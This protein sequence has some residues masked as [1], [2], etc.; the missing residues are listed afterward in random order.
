VKNENPETET[1]AEA[2]T[3]ASKGQGGDAKGVR[4]KRWGRRATVARLHALG[5]ARRTGASERD[6]EKASGTPR[7]T[8]RY[9]ERRLRTPD[10]PGEV[11][12]FF[13]SPAGLE[14]LHRIVV[15]AEFVMTLRSPDGIRPV[16]EFLHLS[17]LAEFVGSSFGSVQKAT[18]QMQDEV[19]AYGTGQRGAL[20]G[21]MQPKEITVCEDE[22]FHPEICLVAIEP[23]S[24]F[25]LLEQYAERRDAETWNEAMKE[26]MTDLPVKVMQSTA[27]EAKALLA[28]AQEAFEAPHSPDVFHVQYE[29]SRSISAPLARRVRQAEAGVEAAVVA[30]EKLNI[31]Q[32]TYEEERQGPGRRR[33]YESRVNSAEEAIK[34]AERKVE[35]AKESQKAA[36]EAVA[37]ISADY[38][39]VRL[40]DGAAQDSNAVSKALESRFAAIEEIATKADLPDRCPAGIAKARR[41]LPAMIAAIQFTHKTIATQVAALQLPDAL[42]REVIDRL[43]P[44]LYLERAASRAPTAEKRRA[45]ESQAEAL[46]SPLRDRG[47]PLQLVSKEERAKIETVARGSA[48]VFQRSSSCVEGRNGQLSLF[49]HG[50]HRLR[51]EKLAALTVIHNYFVRRADGTTAAERFFGSPPDDLFEHLVTKMPPPPRP[52]QRRAVP[53]LRPRPVLVEPLPAEAA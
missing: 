41:V 38:H 20:G 40:S 34:A 25:I 42:R 44:G 39:P 4:R 37:G 45:V 22:T 48:E 17:G 35:E 19:V 9:W 15:A 36:R 8:F 10:R 21:A 27:D 50:L 23:A 31:E 3:D 49:H 28:H 12:E 13:E 46:L 43:V 16:C 30:W 32:A 51:P 1:A 47:H 11:T 24:G 14:L 6:F 18:R 29:L 7:S 52:A 33:D 2:Y 26:A 5:A 53:R